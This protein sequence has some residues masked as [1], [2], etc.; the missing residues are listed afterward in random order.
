MWVKRL[1]EAETY[2]REG[3]VYCADHGIAAFVA[4]PAAYDDLAVAAASARKVDG[5]ARNSVG[6]RQTHNGSAWPV[7][8]CVGR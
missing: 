7:R 3:M 2:V 4:N 1:A 6:S 8:P 5:G